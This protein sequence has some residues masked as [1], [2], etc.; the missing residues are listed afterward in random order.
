MFLGCRVPCPP[1]TRCQSQ[2]QEL[3]V[4]GCF[5]GPP[6]KGNPNQTGNLQCAHFRDRSFEQ[7][8]T[9]CVESRQSTGGEGGGGQK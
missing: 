6:V 3:H 4:G 1:E 2:Q 5:K 7:L 9:Y 8:P